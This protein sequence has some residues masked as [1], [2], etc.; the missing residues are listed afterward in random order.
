MDAISI[1]EANKIRVAMGMKPLPVPGKENDA[2][3]VFKEPSGDGDNSDEEPASTL[4][5][6]SA[7][8]YDN[9]HKMEEERAAK[10]KLQAKKDAIKK[11]REQAQRF[12]KLEGQGLGEGED[13]DA[14]TWLAGQKKRQK[15]IEK[16]RRLEQELA[17]REA[18]LQQ[19][20]TA[21]DLAGVKV[22]HEF[23]QLGEG[24]E[25][26]LTLKDAAVDDDEAGDE[27]EDVGLAERERLNER[28]ESK[29]RKRAYDPNDMDESGQKSILAQY[30][31]EIDGKKRKVFT[32][33]GQGR[34][35]EETQKISEDGTL[36]KSKVKISLDFLQEDTP[37]SDYVDPSEV[38]IKKPKKKKEKKSRKKAVDDDDILPTPDPAVLQDNAGMEIDQPQAAPKKRIVEDVIDDEDLQA[39]LAMQRRAALKKRKKV[40]PEDLA[41]QLREEASATP[42]I[43]NTVEDEEE[44]GLVID[45][46]TEFVANLQG[47]AERPGRQRAKSSQPRSRAVSEPA[48]AVDDEGDVNMEQS[49]AEAGEAEERKAR[50][51]REGRSTSI[52]AVTT[53]G[54]DEEETIDRGVAATLNLLRQRGQI[55]DQNGTELNKRH[56]EHQRFLAEKQKMEAEAEMR[57]KLQRERDRRSG[58][59][60]HM[61]ARERE[62]MAQK[63]NQE[64]D[65]LESRKMAEIFNKEYKP[66]V[67]LNYIDEFGRRMNQ[68][69][70]FKHLSH[71]FHGKGSGKQKTEKRLKKI[72]EE[73]KREAMSSLDSSQHTAMNTAMEGT[74]KK[75]RQAG[76]RLQ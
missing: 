18:A 55:G 54:L 66:N 5:S 64:R 38:K 24:E 37:I 19:E 74:A 53:T 13:V 73:K 21:K 52:P 61:S 17:E 1:E 46:T 71:Q 57:A 29:K 62:A 34:T 49:Y 35:V 15:K 51:E 50:E 26:I 67:E 31:E 11:A 70:A 44:P 16:A 25:H 30:D 68:K 63:A 20:Y 22:A 43:M 39:N 33:D 72:E 65:R 40:K 58:R 69:E 12:A 3:P 8:A 59:L 10:A 45:E 27:L 28:L 9:W 48:N 56:I 23:D 60:E 32:L 47:P 14:R 41:R 4:E 6:R 7:A 36:G 75:N 42:D 2:G 76:V